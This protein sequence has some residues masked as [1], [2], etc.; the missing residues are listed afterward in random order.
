MSPAQSVVNCL[1]I[2]HQRTLAGKRML[3][4]GCGI[5]ASSIILAEWLPELQIFGVELDPHRV[6]LAQRIAKNRGLLNVNF[7]VSPTPDSLPREVEQVDLIL[8]SA[9]YEHF[10]TARAEDPDAPFV[11]SPQTGR[12]NAYQSDA[13]P[14]AP[15]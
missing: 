10:A 2:S 8:L 14:V 5:G 9:V 3:D 1:P 15:I 13:L 12:R 4:F 7:Q 6:E 11:V